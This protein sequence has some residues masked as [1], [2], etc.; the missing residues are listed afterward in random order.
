MIWNF[1]KI[2]FRFLWRNKTYTIL[3]F[4][5]LTFGLSCSI[6]ASLHINRM[7]SFDRFHNNFERLYA[8]EANVEPILMETDFQNRL[9]QHPLS[10]TWRKR[11]LSLIY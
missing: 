10:I 1:L 11:F 6:I 5:C 7:L 8:V 2:A 3:N 4:L 9:F